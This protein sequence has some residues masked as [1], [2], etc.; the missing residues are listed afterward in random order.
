[1][2]ETERL[3]LRRFLASDWSSMHA[4][5]SDPEVVR[6]EPYAPF[7]EAASRYEAIARAGNHA[8]W[9]VCLKEGGRLIGNVY[10]DTREENA[11]ELGYVFLREIWGN[12]YATEAAKAMLEKAFREGAHRVYAMCNPENTASWK[13]LERLHMRREA[14]FVQNTVF[15]KEIPAWQDTY[16]YAILREEWEALPC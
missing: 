15:H 14:H 5:L 7:T 9:A 10:L 16:V 11:R 4:Y 12:G 8:F 13:L 3:I 6:F 2:I 1:M